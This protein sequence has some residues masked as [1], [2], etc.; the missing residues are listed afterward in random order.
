MALSEEQRGWVGVLVVGGTLLL[1]AGGWVW[2]VT[3]C[4]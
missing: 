1:L 4:L 3:Q 2:V